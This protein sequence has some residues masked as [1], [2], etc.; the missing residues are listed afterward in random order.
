MDVGCVYE[1]IAEHRVRHCACAAA[2]GLDFEVGSLLTASQREAHVVS[3]I[4]TG[5]R[6]A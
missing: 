1:L 3:P 5:N 4:H 6:I 2:L